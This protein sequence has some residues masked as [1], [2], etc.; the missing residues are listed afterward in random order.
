MLTRAFSLKKRMMVQKRWA[1]Q[2]E[3][4]NKLISNLNKA[5][6]EK[7]NKTKDFGTHESGSYLFGTYG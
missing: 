2:Q 6:E 1:K 5:N 7:I 3:K 4:N